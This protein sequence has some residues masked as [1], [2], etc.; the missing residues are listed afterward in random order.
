MNLEIVSPCGIDCFNCEFYESNVTEEFQK[1]ISEKTKIPKNMIKCKGC[2]DGNQCLFMELQGKTCPTLKC[3]QE[4]GIGFCFECDDF[5]CMMLMPISDGAN[6]YPHNIK[7]FNLC[8]MKKIGVDK[9]MK[10]SKTI[11]NNYF[12]NKFQ[13][14]NGGK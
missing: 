5:P 13:I 7:L 6:Q 12:T 4:K 11:R 14:G 8:M 10:S 2:S 3:T 1:K 9:W